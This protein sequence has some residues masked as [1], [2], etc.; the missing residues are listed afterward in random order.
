M[1]NIKLQLL[2]KKKKLQLWNTV[3]VSLLREEN[4]I[5]QYAL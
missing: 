3:Q 2:S 5:L 4:T 1:Y